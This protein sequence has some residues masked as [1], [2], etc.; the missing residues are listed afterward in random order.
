MI[1]RSP[2]EYY[3]K[4]LV[5]HPL[6]YENAFIQDVAREL[7]LDHLGEWYITWLRERVR[8][9]SP[10]FPEDVQH[11]KSQRFLLREELERVF[12]PNKAMDQ[13]VRLLNRPRQRELVETMVLSRAPDQAIVLALQSRHSTKV[14]EE[15]VRLFRHYFW[16]IDLLES[17]EMR[18]LLDMRHTGAL[19]TDDNKDAQK[20]IGSIKRMRYTDPRVV[21]ARLPNSPLTAVLAQLELGV[22][23]K[24]IDLAAVIERTRDIAA[25]RALDSVSSGGPQGMQMG[26]GYALIVDVM[27]RLQASIVKPEDKLREDLKKISMAT[28]PRQVPLLSQL[29]SG[30]HTTNVHPEPKSDEAVPAVI[31]AEFSDGDDQDADDDQG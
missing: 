30:N 31:D 11:V 17:V 2:A 27:H 7:G 13:A 29:T 23:P 21:A 20:Q 22:F 18:A 25:L 9:P 19:A 3:F 26:Q 16:N 8:P 4:Y 12:N 28:T 15:A 5:V 10:F 6:L 24:K 14:S 1:R